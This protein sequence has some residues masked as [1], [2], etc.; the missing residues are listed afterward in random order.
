MMF[1]LLSDRDVK[2]LIEEGEI[3]INPFDMD[4]QLMAV[5][6]DLCLGNDFVLFSRN[7]RSHIDPSSYNPEEH[8]EKLVIN[9]GQ[10]FILH[11]GE[12]VL[13]ITKENV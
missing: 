2:R 1:M 9:D 3:K 5:G 12:F 7:Q 4:K 13:G 10:K 8:M 11:P 6:V